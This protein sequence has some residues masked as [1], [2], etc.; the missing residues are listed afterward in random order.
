MRSTERVITWLTVAMLT[1][2]SVGMLT[3]LGNIAFGEDEGETVQYGRSVLKYGYPSVFDGRSFILLDENYHPK[4]YLRYTSPYL[5]FYVAA[6]GL[7]LS[8]Q[9]GNT[10][11]IR[12]PFALSAIA[13]VWGSWFL[14]RK[15]KYSPFVLFLY[16]AFLA[17]SV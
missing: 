3:N 4:N 5:Q 17:T 12:L 11:L 8:E 15:L 1:I 6:L 9:A 10:F 7:W 2:F 16:S 13:G 14:F